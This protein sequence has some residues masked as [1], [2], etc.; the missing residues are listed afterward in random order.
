[1][2]AQIIWAL[3]GELG[4]VTGVV[5]ILLRRFEKR[6]DKRDRAKDQKEE[7]RQQ[8]EVLNIKM[9]FASLSVAEATAEAVQRIP[10]AHCNGEMHAALES[11]KAAKEEYRAFEM[12][13]TAR[14]LH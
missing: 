5:G 14:S 12:K 3:L 9:S 7:A 10:D 1:M 13:Q 11:A 2:E 8:Y 6:L 4:I